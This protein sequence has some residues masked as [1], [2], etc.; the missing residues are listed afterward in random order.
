[1]KINNYIGEAQ[2]VKSYPVIQNK[3]RVKK[4][5]QK[6]YYTGICPSCEKSIGTIHLISETDFLEIRCVCGD[7]CKYIYTSEEEYNKLPEKKNQ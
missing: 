4:M 3:G 7:L 2:F 5:Y 1:M 6:G